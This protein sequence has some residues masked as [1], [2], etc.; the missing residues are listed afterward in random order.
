MYLPNEG[1]LSSPNYPDKYSVS[2]ACSRSLKPSEPNAFIETEL[3]DLDL[4]ARVGSPGCY[5]RLKLRS[6]GTL[7]GEYC[8][9]FENINIKKSFNFSSVDVEFYSDDI[10]T[11][12]G[13]LLHYKGIGDSSW[14][15]NVLFI[16]KADASSIITE[17]LF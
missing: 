16:I 12:K 8:G 17:H 1:F 11:M 10:T 2:V 15:C 5:D 13:F 9:K 4:E 14:L 6:E 3:V 7:Y